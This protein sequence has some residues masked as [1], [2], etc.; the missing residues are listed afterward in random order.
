MV[1]EQWFCWLIICH[2]HKR[3]VV[4]I[5][6]CPNTIFNCKDKVKVGGSRWSL[7]DVS[8]PLVQLSSSSY[9]ARTIYGQKI[10]TTITQV[11]KRS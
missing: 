4:Q 9:K 11:L 3:A 5:S 7:I 10:F 6:Y 1:G 8:Q 2:N